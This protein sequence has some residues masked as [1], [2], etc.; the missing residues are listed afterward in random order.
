MYSVTHLK[1]ALVVDNL[2]MLSNAI[3]WSVNFIRAAQDWDIDAF[4]ELLIH[5]IPLE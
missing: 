4:N 2:E 1:D 3:Q 5:Y